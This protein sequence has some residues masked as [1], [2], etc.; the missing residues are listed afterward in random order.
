MYIVIRTTD[1]FPRIAGYAREYPGTTARSVHVL[2]CGL[3]SRKIEG[4]FARFP[5]TGGRTAG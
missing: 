5:K 4:F 2:D 3:I 1:F